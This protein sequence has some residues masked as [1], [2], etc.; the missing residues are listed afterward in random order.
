MT[1]RLLQGAADWPT[2][3]VSFVVSVSGSRCTELVSATSNMTSCCITSLI[4]SSSSSDFRRPPAMSASPTDT[5][6]LS[7]AHVLSHSVLNLTLLT[8]ETT[9]F[10]VKS[11]VKY[12]AWLH[13]LSL[14][15]RL[16]SKSGLRPKISQKVKSFFVCIQWS[17][18]LNFG[19]TDCW[20]QREA[21]GEVRRVTL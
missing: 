14:R 3:I 10:T 21:V 12:N 11:S 18:S 20:A 2:M 17:L 1:V 7:S 4:T 5:M 13:S 19:L 9:Q 15:P 6:Q 8:C 16:R